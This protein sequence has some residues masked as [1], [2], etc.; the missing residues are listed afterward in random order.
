MSKTLP[1]PEW[2]RAG[3]Q[4]PNECQMTQFQKSSS[5]L[6]SFEIWALNLI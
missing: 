2:R 1:S 3:R 5:F 4:M 6:R